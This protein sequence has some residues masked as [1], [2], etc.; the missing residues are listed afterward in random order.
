MGLY[1]PLSAIADL[2]GTAYLQVSFG[3][4]HGVAA[5]TSLLLYIGLATGSLIIPWL[6]ERNGWLNRGLQLATFM[7]LGLFAILIYVPNLTL[8]MLTALMLIIGLCAGSVTMAF[9]GAVLFAT[10]KQSGLTI[11]VVNLLNMLGGAVLQQ[12]IGY[13]LDWHW[14]GQ[15]TA[16]GIR[17]Y[18][19]ADFKF[20][21]SSIML[22]I[23]ICAVAS[24]ALTTRWNTPSKPLNKR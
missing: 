13:L 1:T 19:V 23:A 3:L 15:L 22:M 7:L 5:Q 16:N 21:L 11:G 18:Q 12:A 2:W 8:T 20:A 6:C 24:L 17:Q 14:S 9:N 10:S 4:S